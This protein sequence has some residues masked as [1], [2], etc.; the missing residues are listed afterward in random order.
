MKK[1]FTSVLLLAMAVSVLAAPRTVEEAAALA[2][3]FKNEQVSQQSGAHRAA[4]KAGEMRLAHQVA[5][6]NSTDPA[7]FVFNNSNGGWV[8]VSADDN[9]F[10][11]L[12]YSDEGSFDA[13]KTTSNVK[14][15]FKYYAE[16]VAYDGQMNES[17]KAVRAARAPRKAKKSY[18]RINPLLGEIKWD[19]GTPW[20]NYC[21][22]DPADD[23]RS[24]TGCVATAAS[25]IMAY[26]QWPAS[27][28]GRVSY[29][30]KSAAG[31][32]GHEEVDFST[33]TYDWDNILP[34]YHE[35]Q[36]TEAQAHAVA[37]LNY[38]VGVSTHMGYGGDESGGS[39]SV[40]DGMATAL[41][42]HFHYKRGAYHHNDWGDTTNL[43]ANLADLYDI[44]LE[45]GR[46]ILMGGGGE[47]GFGGHEIICDGRDE[48]RF[49]H[50]NFG[51]GGSSNGFYSL[52]YLEPWN[53][54]NGHSF[55]E[56]IDCVLGIEPDRN[57]INVTNVSF[58]SNSLD[59][60]TGEATR[61]TYTITPSN[62]SNKGVYWTS[63]DESVATVDYNGYVTGISEGTATITLTT[64]N[65]GYTANCNVTISN[66]YAQKAL[67]FDKVFECKWDSE[68]SRFSIGLENMSQ[69]EYPFLWFQFK[70]QDESQWQIAGFYE[71][72]NGNKIC[73]WPD[74]SRPE[75]FTTSNSGWLNITCLSSNTYRFE[76][77]FYGESGEEYTFAYTTAIS[78][79]GVNLTDQAGNNN[80]YT[81]TF[82]SLGETFATYPTN[83]GRLTLPTRKP[84]SCNEMT[85][86]GWTTIENYNG[87]TAPALAQ[88]GDIVSGN[89]TYYAVF[90]NP[91]GGTT[92]Y[93]EVA[94]LTFKSFANEDGKWY[95]PGYHF[96]TISDLIESSNNLTITDGAWLRAGYNGLK[97]GDT[98]TNHKREIGDDGYIQQ[99]YIVFDLNQGATITKVVVTS[100]K[101]QDSDNGKLQIDLNDL[102]TQNP[103]VYGENIEYIPNKPTDATSLTLA[104]TRKRAY[105]KSVKLYTGGGESY[106]N[107]TTT[108]CQAEPTTYNITVAPTTNGNVTPSLEEAEEG[109]VV[110]INATPANGYQL[111]EVNVIAANGQTINVLHNTAFIMPASDVTISAT[112]TAIPG[113][114]EVASIVF[115]QTSNTCDWYDPGFWFDYIDYYLVESSDN[116]SVSDGS[117][118]RPGANGIR[119]GGCKYDEYQ[120]DS[121]GYITLALNEAAVITKV[122]VNC[123]KSNSNDNGKLKITLGNRTSSSYSYSTNLTYKPSNPTAVST[124]KLATTK[125]AAAIRSVTLYTGSDNYYFAPSAEHEETAID[126]IVEEQSSVRKLIENGQVVIIRGNDKYTIFGQKIQ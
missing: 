78:M 53:K 66:E 70:K 62:A 28:E 26:W 110:T 96:N 88:K 65:G 121:P 17:E 118:L 7:L 72:G 31:G 124:V 33:A 67:T 89:T 37:L 6:P 39:G 102:H 106:T 9:A 50:I 103:I 27:G 49:Y 109:Q 57:P 21:P 4:R 30:W 113:Y 58:N 79:N 84:L 1:F 20:N 24:Y 81:V 3:N 91:D 61:L 71:L 18:T 76:G 108:T 123:S 112:F 19:Q 22:I 63:S 45:A 126:E 93:T 100:S 14:W 38:H 48:N 117:W 111:S 56:D 5:K 40:T 46:P 68:K 119:I 64:N 51:W 15:L 95:D 99:A 75:Y 36:Y 41:K 74:S 86:I 105:I 42:E 120:Q 73:G 35:G 114:T 32:F 87:A 25:Q 23:T 12:G 47:G 97:L 92:P 44:E 80:Q 60:K 85:F 122:V 107:Y 101:T 16:R 54:N 43:N 83:N 116:L 34:Q 59:L 2:A 115:Y 98:N 52:A 104:T 10:D 82:K 94:S 77:V 90:A 55:S 125:R 29:D 13:A 69:G 8:I 11:I